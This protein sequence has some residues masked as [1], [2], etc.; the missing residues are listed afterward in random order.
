MPREVFLIDLWRRYAD[1]AEEIR[2]KKVSNVVKLKARAKSSL[3][4]IKLPEDVATKLIEEYRSKG[5]RIVEF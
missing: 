1:N 5:K 3:V 4:T 2:V